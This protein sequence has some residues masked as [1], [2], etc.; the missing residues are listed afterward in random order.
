MEKSFNFMIFSVLLL[1]LQGCGKHESEGTISGAAVGSI[2]GSAVSS[3]KNKGE[4]AT[5]GAIIGGYLGKA[6][7]ATRDKR[8]KQEE[9]WQEVRV[10]HEEIDDLKKSTTKWCSVCSLSVRIHDATTCP[11]C[12]N[13]LIS[14]KYC[15]ECSSIF[16]PRTHYTYC[17]YCRGGIRLRSR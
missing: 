5:W 4:G 15:K 10:L 8:E 14:K 1:S 7:G 9:H 13:D 17:P 3:N 16:D 2:I 11:S 12:G 6:A